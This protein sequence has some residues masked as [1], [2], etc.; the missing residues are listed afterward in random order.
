MMQ[1]QRDRESER[2]RDNDNKVC[3]ALER[4]QID[5]VHGEEGEEG[6]YYIGSVLDGGFLCWRLHAKG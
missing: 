2:E 1:T 3:P 5:P 4:K 6:F